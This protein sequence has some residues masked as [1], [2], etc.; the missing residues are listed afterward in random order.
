MSGRSSPISTCPGRSSADASAASGRVTVTMTSASLRTAS[1]SSTVAPACSYASS[2]NHAAAPAPVSTSTS[3][4][5]AVS[6]ATASGTSATRRSPGAVSLTAAT[7]TAI[8]AY[9]FLMSWGRQHRGSTN[10]DGT[11]SDKSDRLTPVTGS[12]RRDRL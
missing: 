12:H 6:R 5:I 10:R 8:G 11:V 7:F 2:E 9:L 4:P 3:T 1:P